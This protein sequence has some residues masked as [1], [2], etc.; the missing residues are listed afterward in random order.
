[1]S[2]Q[3][4]CRSPLVAV[5]TYRFSS[6]YG[7]AYVYGALWGCARLLSA[8]ATASGWTCVNAWMDDNSGYGNPC[9]DIARSMFLLPKKRI[10]FVVM[11]SD[12]SWT[13]GF[14]SVGDTAKSKLGEILAA[15]P[16]SDFKQPN[17]RGRIV[18]IIR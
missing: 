4:Y 1:M 12:A 3:I 8:N 15:N 9:V 11:T 2:K 13:F 6:K 10:P 5:E 14:H 16:V 18:S 7:N 17:S